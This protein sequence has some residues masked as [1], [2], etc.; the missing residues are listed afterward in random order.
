MIPR[1][2]LCRWVALAAD[3]LE[4]LYKLLRDQQ[5]SHPYLQIDETPIVDQN[6]SG[7]VQCDGYRAYTSFQKQRAGPIELAACWAHARRKFYEAQE[8]APRV[9]VL[10]T[11]K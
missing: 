8:L 1:Q 3:T 4:P 5:K 6:F 7:I 2:T 11:Q 10:Q 9:P